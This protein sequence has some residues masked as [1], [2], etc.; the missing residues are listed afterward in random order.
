MISVITVSYHT[1]PWLRDCLKSLSGHSEI[2]EIIVIDNGNPPEDQAWL[3]GLAGANSMIR[4]LRPGRNLGFAA[5][6]NRGAA[7]ATGSHVA[8]VNPD[9][10]VPAESFGKILDVFAGHPEIWLCGGRLLNAD[11]SEQRGSRREM[12]TPWRCCVELLRLDRLAPRHPYF[13]RLHMLDHQPVADMM[14]VP[15]ISGAFMVMARDNFLSLGGM[16]EAMFLHTEDVDLCMRVHLAGGQVVYCGHVPVQHG[17]STSNV[18]RSFV[19]WHKTRSTSRYF[20]KH[21]RQSYPQS[22][23][24]AVSALLWCRFVILAMR[25]LPGDLRHLLRIKSP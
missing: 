7:M 13:R 9:V 4:L 3:D 25:Q 20:F 23:L 17:R 12:L 8:F 18:A 5:A 14:A 16:D 6:C 11:G 15:T 1:G 24:V 21:F 10:T 22:V 19:E 2:G